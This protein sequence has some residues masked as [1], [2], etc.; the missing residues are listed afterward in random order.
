MLMEKRTQQ[1]KPKPQSCEG[2][3]PFIKNSSLCYAQA[4]TS[5]GQTQAREGTSS[6]TNPG[7]LNPPNLQTSSTQKDAH[8]CQVEMEKFLVSKVWFPNL[9][10]SRT[11][12]ASCCSTCLCLWTDKLAHMLPLQISWTKKFSLLFQCGR[13]AFRVFYSNL[14]T[15]PKSKGTSA[16]SCIWKALDV[17]IQVWNVC[18]ESTSSV[19]A[20][21]HQWDFLVSVYIK[22]AYL[23]APIFLAY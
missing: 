12:P 3:S 7:P 20:S 1:K 9:T 22:D 2:S 19:Q 15:V 10:I 17:S 16:P 6:F 23:H 5:Q 18:M 21:L 14:F 13:K 4:S 11:P 8:T